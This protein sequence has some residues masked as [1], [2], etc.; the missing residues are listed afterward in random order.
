[1]EKVGEARGWGRM[2]VVRRLEKV[3]G[4]KNEEGREK[5]ES[6]EGESQGG[7]GC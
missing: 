7:E 4:N 2:Q 6:R 5:N 1:M 3:E